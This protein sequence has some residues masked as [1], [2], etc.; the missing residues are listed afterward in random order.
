M[1]DSVRA[2]LYIVQVMRI[3][4]RE[5]RI[6]RR[7]PIYWFC[8]VAFPLLSMVFFTSMMHEGVPVDTPVGVVDLDNTAT[9]RQLVR[10]LDAFPDEPGRGTLPRCARGPARHAAR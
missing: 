1:T 10:R 4:W 6:L 5:C 9:S 3:A 8:M 7:N 2:R